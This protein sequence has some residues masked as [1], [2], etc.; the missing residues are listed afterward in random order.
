MKLIIQIP[1]LNEAD[2]LPKTLAA[3]PREV[4]GFEQVETLVVDDGSTDGTTA[5]A[6]AAGVDHIVRLGGH[7]GLACAFMAGL[8]AA[9]Q[10]GADVIIN[11]DADNQYNAAD[12]PALTRPILDGSADMVIGAR[13]IGT[14]RHFSIAKRSLEWLG[15]RVIKAI[16][17]SDI[18]DAPSGFR[19][20]TREVALRL[21]VFSRFT[22]TL[23]TIIQATL[24]GLRVV[25]VPVRV[26][27]PTRESRL[28]RSNFG[29]ACRG[30]ATILGVYLTYRPGRILGLIS[31]LLIVAGGLVGLRYLGLMLGGEGKGHV[32]SLILCA[33]LMV[34]GVIVAV[35]AALAHLLAINRR[36]LEELRISARARG[37]LPSRPSRS[38]RIE[39]PHDAC[40][41]DDILRASQRNRPPYPSECI[42]P[43]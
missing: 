18:R 33:I 11:T 30:A 9:I 8:S 6:L 22:Y 27:E 4:N 35:G 28:F 43:V 7:Q 20:M 13:P 10:H 1:C 23:E 15:S 37:A 41:G 14:L 5:T 32:Q 25:S 12:I 19:A 21:N 2:T 38:E 31:L 39:D 24:G 34:S 42:R 29:Y 26:N 36:L 3:L 17:G 16:T 40:N